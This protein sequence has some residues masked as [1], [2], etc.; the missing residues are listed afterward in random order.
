MPG[1]GANFE[2][3]VVLKR[4]NQRLKMQLAEIKQVRQ[5]SLHDELCDGIG[6]VGG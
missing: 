1:E 3:F 5:T 2:A 4:E 6:G